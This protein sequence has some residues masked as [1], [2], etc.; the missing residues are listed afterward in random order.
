M[1]WH[2]PVLIYFARILDVSIGTLR[3]ILVIQGR[4]YL[5]TLL[6]FTESI[7]WVI[8]VSQVIHHIREGWIPLLAYGAGFATGTLVGMVIEQRIA[9]GQQIIRIV[10]TDRSANVS[11]ILRQF[12]LRVTRVEGR[13]VKG[14]VEVAFLALPRRQTQ[15][16]IRMILEH[17]P[18]A[19]ITVEDVRQTSHALGREQQSRAQGWMKLIKFK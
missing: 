3:V 2:I 18:G 11:N 15:R 4:K 17:C 7:I 19:F 14:P 12:G 6:G 8:A 9:L 10:N 13:G 1:P 5:A 16:T